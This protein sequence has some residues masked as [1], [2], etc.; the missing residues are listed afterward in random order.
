MSRLVVLASLLLAPAF[1][2]AQPQDRLARTH[3]QAGSSYYEQ[4]RWSDALQEFEEAYRLS[5]EARKPAL[6]YNI[7]L[8]QERLGR[9]A[10][11]IESFRRYLE[12]S[13]QARDRETL[14]ERIR[15]LQA[16]L[17]ATSLALEVS[18][19]GA[20]IEVDGMERGT[21]PLAEPLR[22]TPGEHEIRI[23]KEG[24]RSFSLRVTV[25]AGERVSAQATLVAEAVQAPPSPPP[26][27]PP[28]PPEPSGRTFTWVA[29]GVAGAA[30]IGGGVLG[31]LALRKR[32]Q[33]NEEADG[34]RPE[35]DAARDDAK[36]LALFADITFGVAV[37][38]AAA[39][40]V[41]FIVEG[42]DGEEARVSAAA[43]PVP[44]AIEGGAG[45]ALAG[46][47]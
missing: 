14:E 18:E 29:A 36:R 8:T 30:A 34:L 26:P 5:S 19:A 17:D 21:T 20:R 16:R 47:L 39:A 13:P 28:P 44:I 25:P 42:G 46:E 10:E 12:D 31:L 22:V 33:A 45:L 38:A 37:L 23:V 35:Y 1:A 41:L 15:T 6:L 3:Y 9:L 32:N 43:L 4:G 2:M 7:G 24:Y 27:P 11:A 40:V